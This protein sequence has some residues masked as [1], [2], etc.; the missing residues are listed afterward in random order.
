MAAQDDASLF[1]R[2]VLEERKKLHAEH[3]SLYDREFAKLLDL[4]ALNCAPILQRFKML[5]GPR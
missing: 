1:W 3:R 4:H 5:A 2:Q